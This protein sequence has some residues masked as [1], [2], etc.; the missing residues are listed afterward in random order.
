MPDGTLDPFRLC[1]SNVLDAKE[2]GARLFNH[3]R[4]VSLIREGD[5]VLG[6]KCINTQTNQPFEVIAQQVINAAGIWGRVSVNTQSWISKCSCKRLVADPD[7]R[8][9]NLAD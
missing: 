9:N 3:S 1:S 2:H 8:I 7:Y 6:V 5:T 4:V